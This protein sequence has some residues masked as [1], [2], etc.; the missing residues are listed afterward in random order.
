MKI[1]GPKSMFIQEQI[2]EDGTKTNSKEIVVNA[3]QQ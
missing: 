1:L 2:E 3:T